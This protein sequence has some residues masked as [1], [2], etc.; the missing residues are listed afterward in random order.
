MYTVSYNKKKNINYKKLKI[1][2]EKELVI[3]KKQKS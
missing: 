1:K 2:T 3:K